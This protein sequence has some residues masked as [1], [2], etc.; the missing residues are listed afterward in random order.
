MQ[1][2]A[3]DIEIAAPEPRAIYTRTQPF[4]ATVS[5]NYLLSGP[6]SEKETRHIELL[7]R[8]S[9][10]EYLPGDSAG[11]IPEDRSEAVTEV[12]QSLQCT[13]DEQVTE[14][15]GGAID[16]R[17][18]LTS[19]LMIGRLAS[20]T[21]KGWAK[22]TGNAELAELVLPENKKKLNDYLWGREFV[23]LLEQYPA[24]L[25][26]PRQLFKL[27]PRL[28]PRLYPIA[29]GQAIHADAL[30]LSV[31]VVLYESGGR[32]R[33]SVYSREIGGAGPAR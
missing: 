26:N 13:G 33:Q 24:K 14:F 28:A 3:I 29:S 17:A 16:L 19:W 18:A 7:L 11:V 4:V 2:E 6:A 9:G 12:L 8:G 25:E 23:D 21:V 22:L 5:D 20:S 1:P 15:Y 32:P 31:R 30:H 10:I 27:L